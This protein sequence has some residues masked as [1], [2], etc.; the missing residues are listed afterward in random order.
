MPEVTATEAARNFSDLLDS[1]EHDGDTFTIVRHGKPVA[2]L[3]P[4][5]TGNGRSILDLL[6]AHQPDDA[7]AE[8]LKSTR[9]L[10][11][12]DDRS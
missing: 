3:Q 12:I 9:A 11:A 5:P 2:H 4:V 8:D 1:I 7:W 10:L 6:A